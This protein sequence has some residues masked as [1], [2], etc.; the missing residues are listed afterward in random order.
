MC[1]K[2]WEE[3]EKKKKKERKLELFCGEERWQEARRLGL[4]SWI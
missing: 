1:E 3:G 2:N 4:P